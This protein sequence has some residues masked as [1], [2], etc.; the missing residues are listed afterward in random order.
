MVAAQFNGCYTCLHLLDWELA[1]D[2]AGGRAEDEFLIQVPAFR[3]KFG[4]AVGVPKAGFACGAIGIAAVDD[5]GLRL[6][7]PQVVLADDDGR[8]SRGAGCECAGGDAWYVREQDGQ[9]FD[10]G[11]GFNAASGCASTESLGGGYAVV[12]FAKCVGQGKYLHESGWGGT[13]ATFCL[14]HCTMREEA[15]TTPA[16]GAGDLG[17]ISNVF[18]NADIHFVMHAFLSGTF[19]RSL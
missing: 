9:V 12:D 5:D 7:T 15:V 18:L 1:A 14:L 16:R 10:R 8:G 17:T 13:H 3:D 4:H 11:V 6:A 19:E 2:D